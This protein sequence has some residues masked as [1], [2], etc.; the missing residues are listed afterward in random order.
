MR[1]GIARIAVPELHF[2]RNQ[3]IMSRMIRVGS[4]VAIHQNRR[5]CGLSQW[6][7]GVMLGVSQSTVSR[8]ENGV[9]EPSTQTL[10]KLARVFRCQVIDL[11][12]SPP[13]GERDGAA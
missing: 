6:D 4:P 1:G 8:W 12:E 10:V 5:R 13:R 11:T 3:R 9:M 7:V 2:V